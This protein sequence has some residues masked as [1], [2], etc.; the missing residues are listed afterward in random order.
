MGHGIAEVAAIA[1]YNVNM[2]DIKDEF[3]QNGYDQIEWSLGKLAEND[4]LSEEESDA[5]LERVTPLVDMADAVADADVVIEAVPEQMEIKKDVYTE[6]EEAAPDH[7]IFATNTS[8]L[9]ITDLAE[10]TERPERFCGMH[11]STRRFGCSW[12]K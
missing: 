11:F 6:L 10:F 8:S 3:V 1:G 4:Q 7:A 5:A 12:S 9:S 2:R